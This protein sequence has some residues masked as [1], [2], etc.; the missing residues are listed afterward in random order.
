MSEEDA[1][2]DKG[3]PSP[4]WLL[5]AFTRI[6][7]WIYRLSGGRLMNTLGGDPICLVSMTGA[8]SGRRRVIPSM[9]VPCD[10][11]VA[12]VASQGGAPRHPVWYYNLKAYPDIVIEEGGR[13]RP[14][15]ARELEGEEKGRVWPVCVA[16]FVALSFVLGISGCAFSG[17]L[18][19]LDDGSY[20]VDCSGG[21]HDWSAC[22]EAARRACR[23]GGVEV[24]SQVSNEASQG[25]GSRDWSA[26]GSEVSRSMNFR[27][28]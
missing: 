11:S 2:A 18:Q 25:V 26:A 6:N 17:N 28:R 3:S 14:M 23:G 24:L 7:F 20:Q 1:A 27:C 4:R 16:A 21:Y 5:K 10:G 8:R 13:R 22:N 12:L 15:R 9:Y 19:T